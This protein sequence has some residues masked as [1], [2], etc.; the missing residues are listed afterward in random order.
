MA[1]IIDPYI[2]ALKV[3]QRQ[4]DDTIYLLGVPDVTREGGGPRCQPNAIAGGFNTRR[5]SR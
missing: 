3:M 2:D 1:G 5:I 4:A